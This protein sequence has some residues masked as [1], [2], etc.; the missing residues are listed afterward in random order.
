MARHSLR[1]FWQDVLF[2]SAAGII[3]SLLLWSSGFLDG[4]ELKTFD[5]RVNLNATPSKASKSII[6]VGLDQV[7]LDWV[8][9]NMGITWPWPRQL[10]GAIID[11]CKRRGA[12]SIGFDVIFTEYTSLEFGYDLYLKQSIENSKKL[13][14]W[15]CIPD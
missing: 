14:P 9:E 8:E 13:R 7:S 10:Y 15:F 1:L 4:I 11:N 3:L 12:E 6:I 2:H 5:I